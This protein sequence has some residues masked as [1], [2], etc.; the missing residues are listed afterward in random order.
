[1]QFGASFLSGSESNVHRQRQAEGL[2]RP[3]VAWCFGVARPRFWRFEGCNLELVSCQF[4]S[5]HHSRSVLYN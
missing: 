2:V 4:S 5:A 3:S 1:M